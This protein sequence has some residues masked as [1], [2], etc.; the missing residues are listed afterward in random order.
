MVSDP[1]DDIV[2]N[3]T[4]GSSG[5]SGSSGTSGVNGTSGSSGSSGTSSTSGFGNDFAY[6]ESNT[7]STTTSTTFQQKVTLQVSNLLSSGTYRIGWYC[8]MRTDTIADF[9]YMRV[10][11]D[12]TT[13]LCEPVIEPKD[14]DN[15][16]PLSGFA[17]VELVTSTTYDF[18]LDYRS[19]NG[20]DTYIRNAR[21]EFW[22]V[23]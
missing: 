11:Q 13:T 5:S 3:G 7:Q 19:E 20:D 1:G 14:T 2:I 16:Y 8:E 18:D 9:M 6:D 12:D 22:R 4:S 21:L 17:Y 23:E 10:Q 15:Y